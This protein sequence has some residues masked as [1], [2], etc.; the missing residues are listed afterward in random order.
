[1]S[2]KTQL[3]REMLL[4]QTESLIYESLVSVFQ[5][6]ERFRPHPTLQSSAITEVSLLDIT[7]VGMT[8]LRKQWR[9]LRIL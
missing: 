5:E 6:L 9:P 1:M 8:R 7:A 2:S 4:Y 3:T